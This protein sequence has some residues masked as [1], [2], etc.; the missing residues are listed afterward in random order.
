MNENEPLE[1]KEI[2]IGSVE[3]D[4]E[5][6]IRVYYDISDLVESIREVG[7]LAPGYAYMDGDKY[8]VFVGIRRLLAVKQLYEQEGKPAVFKAYVFETKPANFYEF[9]REENVKRSD[10]TGLDKVH[11]ILNF[12]FAEKVLSSFDIRFIT[13]VQKA[14]EGKPKKDIQELALVEQRA[15]A[16][17]HEKHLLLQEILFL[18]RELRSLEERKLYAIFFLV[19]NVHVRLFET[20]N[21]K[22]YAILN[23]PKLKP[24]ELEIAGLSKED[25]DKIIAIYQ[26]PPYQAEI[27]QE[28]FEEKK[29][30][31]GEKLETTEETLLP[32]RA[33]EQPLEIEKPEEQ[34][35]EVEKL[36]REEMSFE[37]KEEVPSE[38]SEEETI[39]IMEHDVEYEIINGHRF[40]LVKD[41]SGIEPYRVKDGQELELAGKKIRIKYR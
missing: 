31:P 29:E 9:I 39:I 34:P 37:T 8:K 1:Y 22:Q 15:K 24:E 32:E 7:Q 28:E 36:G 41:A 19:H 14:L 12:P 21:F 20:G 3:V 27:I 30:E 4:E 25:V 10:L 2:P 40:M 13:P 17:G 33:E 38:I 35:E 5:A 11:I 6:K 23:A 26:A 18:F 16:K